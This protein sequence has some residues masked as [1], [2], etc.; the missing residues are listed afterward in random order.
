MGQ[1]VS[2]QINPALETDPVCVPGAVYAGMLCALTT[3][4]LIVT[5]ATYFEA[6]VSTTHCTIG[7]VLGFGLVFGGASA[8]V[9][10]EKIDE[11]P[12]RK[13]KNAF[14]MADTA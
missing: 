9:W 10:N 3:S 4:A 12:Y 2:L 7:A 6:A 8:I 11:F 1:S 13:G 14:C 5:I